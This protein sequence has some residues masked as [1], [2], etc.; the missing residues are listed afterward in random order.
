MRPSFYLALVLVGGV[1]APLWAQSFTFVPDREELS[2]TVWHYRE[3]STRTWLPGCMLPDVLQGTGWFPNTFYTDY[4]PRATAEGFEVILEPGKMARYCAAQMDA[5][6]SLRL[7]LSR[8][9]APDGVWGGSF[10]VIP[11]AAA[12]KEATVHCRLQISE[13]PL[14][15][16]LCEPAH[17][18]LEKNGAYRIFIEVDNLAESP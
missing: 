12:G 2:V 18:R 16:L 8:S 3:V 15:S 7:E 6:N 11:D 9:D 4:S 5:Y 10:S 17:I 13:D 14:A 1:S